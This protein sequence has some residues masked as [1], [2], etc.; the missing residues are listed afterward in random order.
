MISLYY[1]TVEDPLG[2]NRHCIDGYLC[3]QGLS[4]IPLSITKLKLVEL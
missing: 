4:I 2:L 1:L 3:N